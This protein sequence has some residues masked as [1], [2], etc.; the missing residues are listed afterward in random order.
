M[1]VHHIAILFCFVQKASFSIIAAVGLCSAFTM[2]VCLLALSRRRVR[3]ESRMEVI[4]R[5]SVEM[6][7]SNTNLQIL[8]RSMTPVVYARPFPPPFD[9]SPTHLTVR[10][11]PIDLKHVPPPSYA[12]AT[13]RS[14]RDGAR[15]GTRGHTATLDLPAGDRRSRS[16][17]PDFS[18]VRL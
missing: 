7:S 18:E 5:V 1:L 3:T 12:D 11:T 8:N 15:V 9:L 16:P 6:R 13:S 4:D 14:C 10:A 2:V 17:P